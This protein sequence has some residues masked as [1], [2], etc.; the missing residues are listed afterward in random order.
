MSKSEVMERMG[1]PKYFESYKDLNGKQVDIFFYHTK[2][3]NK[4]V[5]YHVTKSMTTPVIIEDGELI[6]WGDEIKK[7]RRRIDIHHYDE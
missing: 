1:T 3:P 2:G 7:K 5:D 6:G 4:W